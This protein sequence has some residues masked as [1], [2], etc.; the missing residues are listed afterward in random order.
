[1]QRLS[2]NLD[3]LWNLLAHGDFLDVNCRTYLDSKKYRKRLA[4]YESGSI[5]IAMPIFCLNTASNCK[6]ISTIL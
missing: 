1:M 6:I 5:P 4:Q 3:V 2:M